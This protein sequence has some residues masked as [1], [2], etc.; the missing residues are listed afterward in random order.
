MYKGFYDGK[1]IDYILI[2]TQAD[3]EKNLEVYKNAVRA[4]EIAK[5]TR[6]NN[7]VAQLRTKK[8]YSDMSYE[9]LQAIAINIVYGKKR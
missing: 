3:F 5:Q 1:K 7:K 4:D 9:Q 2:K 8:S 6:I